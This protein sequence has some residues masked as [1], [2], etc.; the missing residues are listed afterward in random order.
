MC[1]VDDH[2]VRQFMPQKNCGIP[3]LNGNPDTPARGA[4]MPHLTEICTGVRFAHL[5][6]IPTAAGKMCTV[7]EFMPK[8]NCVNTQLTGI[9]T[10]KMC[11]VQEFMPNKSC[12]N[13]TPDGNSYSGR[14]DVH[15]SR[16]YAKKELEES[17]S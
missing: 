2:T 7:Q 17:S 11:T 14:E 4:A 13:W 12:P 16:V 6:E 10:G 8:T 15:S 3:Q 5:T 1:R 9:C